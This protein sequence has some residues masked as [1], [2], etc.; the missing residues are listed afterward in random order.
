MKPKKL[1]ELKEE[2]LPLPFEVPERYFDDLPMRMQQRIEREDKKSWAGQSMALLGMKPQLLFPAFSVLLLGVL[3]YWMSAPI[4]GTETQASV[5][6]GATE[7]LAQV[8]QED[9]WEYVEGEA[10]QDLEELALDVD[11]QGNVEEDALESAVLEEFGLEELQ[12][13]L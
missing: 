4:T 1:A 2:G 12:A 11:W 5:E 9:L 6:M 8:P 13:E 3:A 10:W 7:L